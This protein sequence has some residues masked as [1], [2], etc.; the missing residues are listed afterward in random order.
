VVL[1]ATVTPFMATSQPRK[2]FLHPPRAQVL[3]DLSGWVQQTIRFA[4]IWHSVSVFW[5][6]SPQPSGR[7][8]ALSALADGGALW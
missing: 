2:P 3:A 8:P 6:C 4:K 5:A 1:A 7:R